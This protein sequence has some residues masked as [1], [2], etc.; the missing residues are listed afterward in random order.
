LQAA[1][2]SLDAGTVRLACLGVAEFT[3]EFKV[4]RGKRSTLPRPIS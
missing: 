4:R 3:L 2:K 1:Q